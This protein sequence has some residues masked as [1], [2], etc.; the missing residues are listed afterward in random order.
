M[1]VN[2]KEGRGKHR[3]P[4]TEHLIFLSGPISVATRASRVAAPGAPSAGARQSTRARGELI[5]DRDGCSNGPGLLYVTSE[6]HEVRM[7]HQPIEDIY[8]EII[9]FAR[10]GL[11]D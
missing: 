3:R 1:L 9:R 8:R 4:T 10:T 2:P 7:G 6:F 5:L 11:C